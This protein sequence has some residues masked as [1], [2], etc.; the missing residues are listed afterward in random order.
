MSATTLNQHTFIT[1]DGNR[2]I[3]KNVRLLCSR[4]KN[5]V[6]AVKLGRKHFAMKVQNNRPQLQSEQY[7]MS[8]EIEMLKFFEEKGVTRVPRVVHTGKYEDRQAFIMTPL[9]EKYDTDESIRNIYQRFPVGFR[10]YR[11]LLHRWQSQVSEAHKTFTQ[12]GID[13][14]HTDYVRV[15]NDFYLVD[16]ERATFRDKK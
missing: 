2:L 7:L 11:R 6:Y 9:G 10:S 14:G 4:H 15:G 16:F 13:V 12:L 8:H 1:D 5:S 3:L